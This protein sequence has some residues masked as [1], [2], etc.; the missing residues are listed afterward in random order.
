[1]AIL[2]EVI[3]DMRTTQLENTPADLP[4]D[5]GVRDVHALRCAQHEITYTVA[6]S[7]KCCLEI[8]VAADFRAHSG[9]MTEPSSGNLAHPE[10]DQTNRG[11]C[12]GPVLHF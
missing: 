6:M 10:V 5:V 8:F 12:R 2:H 3:I 9:F 4:V 7:D 1:M 11:P